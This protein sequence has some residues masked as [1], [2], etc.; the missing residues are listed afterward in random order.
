[1]RNE[2]WMRLDAAASMDKAK[3]W[4]IYLRYTKVAA[5]VFSRYYVWMVVY[6]FSMVTQSIIG[7]YLVNSDFPEDVITIIVC[8]SLAMIFSIPMV[9]F[10][11]FAA[12][13][14]RL[15]MIAIL[16]ISS[17]ACSA[18]A[19]FIYLAF[20]FVE[21]TLP[22]AIIAKNLFFMCLLQNCCVAIWIYMTCHQKIDSAYREVN[23]FFDEQTTVLEPIQARLPED[24]R[25][26][27]LS[28]QIENKH[29]NVTTEHGV[30]TVRLPIKTA[31]KEFDSSSGGVAP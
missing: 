16:T 28:L 5:W 26:E 18:L 12:N 13:I 19:V 22:V 14:V 1:M 17:A 8:A 11:F 9:P 3:L 10:I 21:T 2:I 31:L 20:F 6:L 30:H 7:V 24:K 25:G 29:L 4:S 27:I 15:P 23:R